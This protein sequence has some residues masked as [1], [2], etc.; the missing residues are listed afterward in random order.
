[1]TI[2]DRIAEFNRNQDGAV[3]V[4]F[5]GALA[6]LLGLIALSFDFG[7]RA[8]TQSELQ[9]Y[10]DHV[11]LAAAGELDGNSDAITRATAAAANLISDSQSFGRTSSETYGNADHTLAGASNYTLA[12]YKTLPSSDTASLNAGLTTKPEDA[13]YV[14]VVVTP[15]IV[16]YTFAAAFYAMMGGQE[17]ANAVSASA[18][19]GFTQYACDITPLMF[20]L[21]DPSYKAD[22]N[23][24]DLILLRSGG[25]GAAWGPGDFG[26]LDP[27]YAKVDPNGPCGGKTGAQLDACLLGAMGS[28]TQC[29]AQRGVDTAPGQKVGIEDASFNVR[30]DMYSAIM[31]GKKND[32][33]YAP[34]PNVIKGV[35]DK[36]GNACVGSNPP[37]T[38]DTYA[39]PKDNCFY[40]S[41]CWNGRFGDGNWS[42]PTNGRPKYVEKNYG[43]AAPDPHPAAQTRYEYYL[44]EIAAAGGGGSST[45]ILTGRS[46]TGRPQC[47]NNQAIDPDRRIVIAAAIDCAANPINGQTNN[48]PVEEFFKLFLTRP[49][50]TNGASPPTLDL[51]GEV[52]GSASAPVGGGGLFHDVVQLYR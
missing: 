4:F 16:D 35:A 20:C 26:F 21:P 51:W 31:N 23:I 52:V 43:P 44:A 14:R 48:V 34:A 29:F 41:T 42:D 12:F 28:I 6:V 7:R 2:R 24:G 9:S 8:S 5:A 50:G 37:E 39:L 3:L 22:A 36:N 45:P 19:A 10:A 46:E 13:S 25:T 15:K 27:S 38:S 1:M 18:V 30:F 33:A 32:P 11:A 17:P 49:V 40:T 47:S